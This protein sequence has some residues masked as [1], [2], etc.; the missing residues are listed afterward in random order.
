MAGGMRPQQI[1]DKTH[2]SIHTVRTHWRN[3]KE[4]TGIN[5]YADTVA[6]AKA[7]KLN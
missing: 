7:F 4:K 1:A 2:T 6:F 3:A 5:S